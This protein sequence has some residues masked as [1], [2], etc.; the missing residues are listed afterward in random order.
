MFSTTLSLFIIFLNFK[1]T[2]LSLFH[3]EID[4]AKFLFQNAINHQ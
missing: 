3:K 1:L 2:S 4:K